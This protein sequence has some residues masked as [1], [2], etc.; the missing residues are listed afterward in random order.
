MRTG[1]L[2]LLRAALVA[3]L[4]CAGWPISAQTL[5]EVDVRVQSDASVVRLR[6][7]AA[8]RFLQQVPT[9]EADLFEVR[10]E[11]VTTDEAIR[12]QASAEFRRVPAQGGLPALTITYEPQANTRTQTLLLRFA[13]AVPLQVRQGGNARSLEFVVRTAPLPP[14]PP[15]PPPQAGRFGV[16]LETLPLAQKDQAKPIPAALQ[17]LEVVTSET[18][19]DGVASLQVAVGFFRTREE[20]ESARAAVL[21]RF[22]QAR[23]VDLAERKAEVPVSVARAPAFVPPPALPASAPAPEAPASAPAPEP[24]ASAPV[25]APPAAPAAEPVPATP[26]ETERLAADMLGRARDALAA[27]RTEAAIS[28]LNDLLKLPPNAQS[29]AAQE[30]IGN[31]WEQGGSPGRARVEYELYLQLYPQGEGARRVSARLAALGVEPKQA[32]A[33]ART[34][35]VRPYNGSIAQYYYGGK[36]KSK[37]LVN[38]SEGI[39]QAT[40]TRTTESAIVTSVDLGARF[41]GEDSEVRG[42]VRGSGTKSLLADTHSSSSISAAYV[43]WRRL[44]DGIAVRGGRQSPISGGL[45]GIFDGVS[46]AMPVGQGLKIDVMGGRPSNALVSAPG[47]RLAAVVVEADGLAERW[48]G[49]AYLLDQTTE[50]IANR[51]ALGTELRYAGD[52]WSLNALVDYDTLF[53]EVNALSVHG[54]VQLGGQTTVTLLVDERRAPSLQLTNAL[55]SNPGF[56]SLKDLLAAKSMAQVKDEALATSAKARQFLLSVARPLD[57]KWQIATDL[58]YSAV[59]ALPKVGDF[60]AQPATGSQYTGTVQLTGTNLYSARDINNFNFSYTTTP[61]LKGM[62]LAYNNLI[63]MLQDNALTLEPSIRLYLQRTPHTAESVDDN[64]TRTTR[65]GPGLRA[66]YKTSLRSSLLTE[67]LYEQSST[68]GPGTNSDSTRSAFFYVG[69]RYELF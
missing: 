49:N 26:E 12:R 20:A 46:V 11:L 64:S 31:A 10:F 4:C 37:S 6:F 5:D 35:A 15:P 38:I 23:V 36:A 65:I 59:G 58:R 48:G 53:K 18:L 34:E 68:K 40:L 39:D 17:T 28:L 42:V 67:L 30:L 9:A 27:R 41:V 63:G 3:A 21:N 45:L 1:L 47:E 69:Y 7:N 52:Q 56:T 33:P 57:T 44:P 66:T 51:R 43:D 61:R 24:A 8:V 54:S 25:A 2:R 13:R 22:P 60:D 14:P 19:V 50:G 16:L 55:I 32:A 29:A 62:Q